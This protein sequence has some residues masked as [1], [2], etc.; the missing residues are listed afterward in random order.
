[1]SPALIEMTFKGEVST[2]LFID[3]KVLRVFFTH[4]I[5]HEGDHGPPGIAIKVRSEIVFVKIFLPRLLYIAEV[6]RPLG[7]DLKDFIILRIA[8][9]FV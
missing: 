3:L 4:L 9:G 7:I 6:I 5:E 2:L 1:M 8:K